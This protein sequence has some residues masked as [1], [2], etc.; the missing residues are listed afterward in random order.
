MNNRKKGS[1][2]EDTAASFLIEKKYRILDKNYRKK[3]GEIDLIA[4]DPCG[5]L[6]FLEV[7]FRSKA[8]YGD[9]AE[10]VN[11]KKQARIYRTAAWYLLEKGLPE[12]TSCRFDVICVLNGT[13]RH[14]ENAFGGL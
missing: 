3:T 7:K 1:V 13:I 11:F 9:P 10:A 2:Y 14:I 5:T 12:T 4:E 8:T 6:V